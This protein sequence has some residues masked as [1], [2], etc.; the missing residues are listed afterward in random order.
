MAKDLG[1]A[2]IACYSNS[3]ACINLI[4]GPIKRYHIYVVLI[5]DL[6]QMLQTNIAVS[7]I[8]IEMGTVVQTTWQSLKLLLMWNFFVM[9]Y[10]L[11]VLLIFL[12]A[13]QLTLC[14]LGVASIF[15]SFL[16]L[17]FYPLSL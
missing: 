7:H 1:Y 17:F 5:Q 8:L 3:L 11:L 9:M 2:E 14:S 4:N 12:V 10:P 13:M 6:K 16:V 15:F